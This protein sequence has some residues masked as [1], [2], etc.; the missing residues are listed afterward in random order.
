MDSQNYL[1]TAVRSSTPQKLRLMLIDGAIRFVTLAGQEFR[2]GRRDPACDAL[3]NARAV[4][5][6]LI[7]SVDRS[8]LPELTNRVVA[9]YV[10]MGERLAMAGFNYDLKLL[11][12]VLA[13]LAIERDTWR[14]VCE[15]LTQAPVAKSIA[16]APHIR[17]ANEML[18]T[19]DSLGGFS[20][21]A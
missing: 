13:L 18:D 19:I 9:L 11:D 20:L 6:E 5:D 8:Q 7:T 10:F 12:E 1:E 16:P 2:T 4:I 17:T 15:Q 21:E 14:Q 3:A